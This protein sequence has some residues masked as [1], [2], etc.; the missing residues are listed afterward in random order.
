MLES[1]L[2]SLLH[3]RLSGNPGGSTFEIPPESNHFSP[4]P[5][6]L[7]G[8]SHCLDYCESPSALFPSFPAAFYSQHGKHKDRSIQLSIA[9]EWSFN[10]SRHYKLMDLPTTDLSTFIHTFLWWALSARELTERAVCFC[11]LQSMNTRSHTHTDNPAKAGNC[12]L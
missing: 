8:S 9:G 2:T 4:P 12:S 10:V 1:L 11:S 6:L 7:P 3:T 5:P